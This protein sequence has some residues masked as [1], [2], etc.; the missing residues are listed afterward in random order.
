[1]IELKN[2]CKTYDGAHTVLDGISMT[3]D[4]GEFLMLIGKS[5]CGKSTLLNI[6]GLLD[7]PTSGEYSFEGRD[8]ATLKEKEKALFRREKIGFIFQSFYLIEEF[9]VIDNVSHPL[10][11]AG[12]KKSERYRI[13]RE[14]LDLLGMADRAT[15]KVTRLSGGEQ[16]RVAIARA[17]VNDPKVILADEPTGN[18]DTQNRDMVMDILQRLHKMGHDHHGHARYGPLAIRQ[19]CGANFGWEDCVSSNYN[20]LS[21]S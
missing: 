12:V 20:N 10:G 5:G 8:L 11:Y 4:S 17:L 1:M 16:Q 21:I 3:I 9:N 14:K 19:L 6:L 13:A 7:D 15:E 18:L 2:I